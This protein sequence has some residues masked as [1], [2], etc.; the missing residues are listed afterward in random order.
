MRSLYKILFK[1]INDAIAKGTFRSFQDKEQDFFDRPP[2]PH[3]K[4]GSI[5][6]ITHKYS[7]KSFTDNTLGYL[8]F[9]LAPRYLPSHSHLKSSSTRNPNSFLSG[10]YKALVLFA[11]ALIQ[12]MCPWTIITGK[13]VSTLQVSFRQRGVLLRPKCSWD[14]S[15][16]QGR[17]RA[18]LLS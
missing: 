5:T 10:S 13:E 3:P 12:P 16:T 1:S 9:S 18:F 11:P 8:C 17:S 6:Y 7:S 15:K 14:R 4:K 2:P